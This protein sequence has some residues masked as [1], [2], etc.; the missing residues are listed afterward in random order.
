MIKEI[1]IKKEN[2]FYIQKVEE[3][4]TSLVELENLLKSIK[5]QRE[6][7][8]KK[9]IANLSASFDS[10]IAELEDKITQIKA[11]S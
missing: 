6:T 8:E 2:K 3:I 9:D 1:I 5:A 10:R 11:L 7:R 4:E